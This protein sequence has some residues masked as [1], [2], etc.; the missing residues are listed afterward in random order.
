MA[1]NNYNLNTVLKPLFFILILSAY[2]CGEDAKVASENS[3]PTVPKTDNLIFASLQDTQESKAL[4]GSYIVAYKPEDQNPK[5]S[6]YFSTYKEESKYYSPL[7]DK[8]FLANPAI[9]H[10]QML[11]VVDLAKKLDLDFKTAFDI[12]LLDASKLKP[13][14]QLAHFTRIDFHDHEQAAE[15][16]SQWYKEDRVWFAEPNYI[17]QP[18]TCGWTQ[19]PE[20]TPY[21]PND[22]SSSLFKACADQYD[23]K[24]DSAST[25]YQS[26]QLK[27]AF[28]A[29]SFR[30]ITNGLNDDATLVSKR[31]IIAVLDSGVDVEHP[32]LAG[33]IWKN[34]DGNIGEAGCKND[35]FGCNTTTSF[36]DALGDG[37]V[38][39][40]GLDGFSQGCPKKPNGDPDGNCAHGTIV[41]SVI[42]GDNTTANVLGICPMC[43]VMPIR[44]V[45]Q[46]SEGDEKVGILDSSILAGLRYISRFDADSESAIRVVNASF[47]K[48][49]RSKFVGVY[50]D[51]IFEQRN[52][53]VIAAA[54]NED[55]IRMSYVAAFDK[56]IAVS[57]IDPKNNDG[58][59]KFSNFGQ[60]V[61]IAAP[62]NNIP[63]ATPGEGDT[64]TQGT[65]F[66]APIVAGVA[67]LL[68]AQN[69]A[70]TSTLLKKWLL[71]T[72]DPSIYSGGDLNRAYAPQ[73]SG[74]SQLTPL[75]G[76]GKLS[77]AAAVNRQVNTNQI[78]TG[79][80]F[81]RVQSLCGVVHGVDQR[82]NSLMSV[83]ALLL[84][85]LFLVL[86]LFKWQ[87]FQRQTQARLKK[88]AQK[89]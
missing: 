19:P 17:S 58:K 66:S 70:I 50:I 76:R 42:A 44:I 21:D 80:D 60:W 29:L 1:K 11:G 46:L 67:G 65:S 35:V 69:P 86:T 25:I 52:A 7:M 9:K 87:V 53:V 36:K 4:Y 64:S 3:E 82:S 6:F 27:E 37:D 24:P 31:P 79:A 28:E 14:P 15:L 47:G 83:V 13:E 40:V 51:L 56:S 43:R 77:A 10:I 63:G 33:R 45:G 49:T 59:S 18:S 48:Y 57:S 68:V 38:F 8:Q 23:S 22:P 12:D 73:L 89:Y 85:P 81:D 39:P 78:P 32:A 30:T 5:N 88:Q 54:G 20:G 26:I 61:D 84:V 2:G 74:N 34:L 16:L 71:E 72:A 75:L 41:S 62:G 55:S